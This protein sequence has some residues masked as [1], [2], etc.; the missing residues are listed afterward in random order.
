MI[1]YWIFNE[2]DNL[3]IDLDWICDI[4]LRNPDMRYLVFCIKSYVKFNARLIFYFYV[5]F[6]YLN[7]CGWSWT[8]R[9]THCECVYLNS[10]G[11]NFGLL[12]CN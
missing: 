7:A 11:C 6:N 2:Y 3:I 4:C 12:D 9:N 8:F 1:K 10:L 5:T